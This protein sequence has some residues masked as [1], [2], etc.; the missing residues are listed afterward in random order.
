MSLKEVALEKLLEPLSF[1]DAIKTLRRTSGI[2]YIDE[3][4]KTVGGLVKVINL[5]NAPNKIEL[6]AAI[7]CRFDLDFLQL[8]EHVSLILQGVSWDYGYKFQRLLIKGLG[9][10]LNMLSSDK[11]DSD[12]EPLE[13]SLEFT[14]SRNREIS[15]LHPGLPLRPYSELCGKRL[16]K[17]HIMGKLPHCMT[18]GIQMDVTLKETNWKNPVNSIFHLNDGNV[19]VSEVEKKCSIPFF[20]NGDD[21]PY[22]RDI[23]MCL[24]EIMGL[25]TT[26]DKPPVSMEL[27]RWHVSGDWDTRKDEFPVDGWYGARYGLAETLPNLSVFDRLMIHNPNVDLTEFDEFDFNLVSLKLEGGQTV[28]SAEF[29]CTRI[30]L[31]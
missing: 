31:V 17:V 13:I 6:Y 11:I 7:A 10:E 14:P 29:H 5:C 19:L 4:L 24:I 28:L 26:S 30:I 16:N 18:R 23:A 3:L 12:D 2:D 8:H 20:W 22:E 15:L 9:E 27:E 25:F 1:S 21:S